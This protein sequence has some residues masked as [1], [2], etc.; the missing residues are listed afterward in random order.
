MSFSGSQGDG[1]IVVGLLASVVLANIFMPH[2]LEGQK[3]KR[4]TLGVLS[5]L[6]SAIVLFT[7]FSFALKIGLDKETAMFV[8]IQYG[9]IL[10][11]L[12]S[13]AATVF[14]FKG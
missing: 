11:V 14:S 3:R 4:I 2:D 7:F 12:S 13:V 1:L 10:T 5:S 9:L 6:A 8:N